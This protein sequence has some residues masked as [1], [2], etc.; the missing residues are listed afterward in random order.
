MTNHLRRCHAKAE[1]DRVRVGIQLT[2]EV[3]VRFSGEYVCNI[4]R[5]DEVIEKSTVASKECAITVRKEKR[6]NDKMTAR[7]RESVI[8]A[9]IICP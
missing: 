8:P 2:T 1:V 3:R 9:F 4:Y 5:A 7:Q 6:L